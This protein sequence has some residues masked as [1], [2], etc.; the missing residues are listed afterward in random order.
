MAFRTQARHVA[1]LLIAILFAVSGV[2]QGFAAA[3]SAPKMSQPA[4]MQ[5]QA[6]DDAMDCC[7]DKPMTPSACVAA[8]A[9]AGAILCESA[10]LP[11]IILPQSVSIGSE[12]A[13]TGRSIPPEPDPP[14]AAHMS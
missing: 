3:G 2:A 11:T 9:I 4:A 7:G 12:I 6:A 13:P 10:A 1:C 5:T 8:C 14:R